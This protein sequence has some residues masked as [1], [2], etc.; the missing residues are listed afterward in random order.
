[1][2]RNGGFHSHG[3]T[4]KYGWFISVKISWKIPIQHGF[5]LGGSP[6]SGNLQMSIS[7][8]N[9]SAQIPLLHRSLGSLGLRT[10][11]AHLCDVLL[12]G[13]DSSHSQI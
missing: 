3:G 7:S 6:I 9:S 4:L 1:M 12:H 10:V 5:F 8:G 13:H 2:S 11:P